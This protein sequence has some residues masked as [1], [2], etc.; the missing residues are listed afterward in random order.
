MYS[1]PR[2]GRAVGW[3]EGASA[4]PM[5]PYRCPGC[6]TR[7]H[8]P[9]TR[10]WLLFVMVLPGAL[11]FAAAALHAQGLTVGRNPFEVSFAAIV[12]LVVGLEVM[13][14]QVGTLVATTPAQVRFHRL[15]FGVATVAWLAVPVA[16]RL[17]LVE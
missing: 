6:D 16:Q 3:L 9:W 5:N 12:G 8:A 7:L 4:L 2:C 15:L 10:G 11:Y 14:W 13:A 17:G 1:C